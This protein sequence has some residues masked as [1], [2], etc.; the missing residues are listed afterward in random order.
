[1]N[2]QGAKGKFQFNVALGIDVDILTLNRLT[3]RIH[4]KKERSRVRS[5][6]YKKASPTKAREAFLLSNYYPLLR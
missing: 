2:S 3:I 6:I 4:G 1:M 5:L